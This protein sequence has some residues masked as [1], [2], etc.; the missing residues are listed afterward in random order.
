[1]LELTASDSSLP[2]ITKDHEGLL[3]GLS[4][5]PSGSFLPQK[6]EMAIEEASLSLTNMMGGWTGVCGGGGRA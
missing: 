6:P 3:K 4:F 2:S 1:M 5:C